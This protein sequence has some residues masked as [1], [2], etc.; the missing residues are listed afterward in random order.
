MSKLERKQ[1]V[2]RIIAF[3]VL[4]NII[5]DLVFP[6]C[7][8]ALTGGPS[9]PEFE[10]FEPAATN[11]MVD[12]FT[13]DLNYNIPLLNIPGPNGGYPV[14]L[15][16]HAGP[17][18]EQEASW[19]GLG[20]NI[21]PGVIN[22]N[23]RGLPDDFNGDVVTKEFNLKDRTGF[24]IS[25][26]WEGNKWCG[27]PFLPT[28]YSLGITYDNYKGF[29]VAGSFSY[30]GN[31]GSLAVNY[32]TQDG[33]GLQ[34]S[35]SVT[36]KGGTGIGL[37]VNLNS[38]EGM[39]SW[40]IDI[41]QKFKNVGS[42]G[43]KEDRNTSLNIGFA[44][45]TQV[46][47]IT[48]P[49]NTNLTMF[50]VRGYEAAFLDFNY[51]EVSGNVTSTKITTNNQP[52]AGYGYCYMQNNPK[53][54]TGAYLLDFNREND[55]PVT[56]DVEALPMPV[57]T[58]DLFSISGEGIG[59]AFRTQ[60]SDVGILSDPKVE[61][62][63]NGIYI[64]LEVGVG[65]LVHA[66]VSVPFILNEKDVSGRWADYYGSINGSTDI[67][68][69][70]GDESFTFKFLNEL[71]T[72]EGA[73]RASIN[74]IVGAES[75]DMNL[76]WDDVWHMFVPQI[77]NSFNG[78]AGAYSGNPQYRSMRR[79]RDK[80]IE[81]RKRSEL[82]SNN[83]GIGSHV[84]GSSTSN[85]PPDYLT[86]ENSLAKY[87]YSGHND[88][89]GEISV[90]KPDGFRYQY[91]IPV[92]QRSQKDVVFSVNATSN[93]TKNF[94]FSNQPYVNE[95][96]YNQEIVADNYDA[97][98]ASISNLESNTDNL[99]QSNSLPDYAGNYLLT[100][101][102]SP[103][104]VDLTGNGP[105]NDD[106][107]YYVKYNYQQTNAGYNWRTPYSG[108]FLTKGNFSDVLD[109][110]ESYMYGTKETWYLH[111]I[112]TKTH[113]A[114]FKTS[115]R[116]DG[117]DA[118]EIS[119]T[120]GSVLQ[121]PHKLK[122]LDQINLY[123]QADLA[124]PIQAINF[125]YD[126][127]LCKGVPNNS[128][129]GDGKLTLKKVWFS[130]LGNNKGQLSPYIFNYED[131]TNGAYQNPHYGT[132]NTDRW[133]NYKDPY[134][135]EGGVLPSFM[136][137]GTDDYPYVFQDL[138]YNHDGTVAGNSNGVADEYSLDNQQRNFN[139]SAW[140]L[141][142]IILPSGGQINIDYEQDEYAYV[143][144]QEATEMFQIVSTGHTPSNNNAPNQAFGGFTEE[145]HDDY[146]RIYFELKKDT[147]ASS[148]SLVDDISKY[149]PTTNSDGSPG[150]HH[151]YFKT[152]VELKS[153]LDF[154]YKARDYVSGYLDAVNTGTVTNG[155][156]KLGFIDVASIPVDNSAS[157]GACHPIRKAAWQHLKLNRH[158]LISPQTNSLSFGIALLQVV[159]SILTDA[160]QVILG[161]YHSCQ[162]NEYAYRLEL[163]AHGKP[164][165]IRLK[166]P[167]GHKKGGGHRVRRIAYTD[168]W[169]QMASDYGSSSPDT[170]GQEYSYLLPDG[171]SSGVASYEPL[172]GGEENPFKMP[173]RTYSPLNGWVPFKSLDLYLEKPYGEKY[174]PAPMVG[175]SRVI[176]KNIDRTTTPSGYTQPVISNQKS[177]AGV[178]VTDFYTAKDFPVRVAVGD[179][180]S[181]SFPLSIPVPLVGT[182]AWDN[183]GYSQGYE[184]VLNNMHG[185]LKSQATYAPM[186]FNK[187]AYGT[188]INSSMASPQAIVEY[189]YNTDS[190]GQLDNNVNVMDYD[191]SYRSSLIG[192][193]GEEFVDLREN[194]RIKDYSWATINFDMFLAA[195]VPVFCIVPWPTINYNESMYR[196]VVHNKIV[197]QTGVL[198]EVRTTKDG[199]TITMNNLMYDSNTGEPLLTSVTNNFN[200][201]VY[202]YNKQAYWAYN[203]MG[204]AYK[205]Y[206]YT[207]NTGGLTS[208]AFTI[209]NG[210]ANNFHLG[211]IVLLNNIYYWVTN[212]VPNLV[213]P[214]TQTNITLTDRNGTPCPSGGSLTIMKSGYTNQ[215]DLKMG[216]IVGLKN[217]ITG[218]VSNSL[219]TSYISNLNSL[220]P[221]CK[222]YNNCTQSQY[223]SSSSYTDCFGNPITYSFYFNNV[224]GVTTSFTTV[225]SYCSFWSTSTITMDYNSIN[226]FFNFGA[227]NYP[228][229]LNFSFGENVPLD[230][231]TNSTV[232]IFTN[233]QLKFIN[234]SWTPNQVI[235][236]LTPG[237]ILPPWIYPS[238]K[239]CIDLDSVLQT[240]AMHYTDQWNFNYNDIGSTN[241]I[242]VDNGANRLSLDNTLAAKNP[243]RFGM[244]GIWRPLNNWAYI[245]QRRQGDPSYIDAN[246]TPPLYSGAKHTKISVDGTFKLDEHDWTNNDRLYSPMNPNFNTSTSITYNPQWTFVSE[247]TNY[248]PYGY[249]TEKV[250]AL[251]IYSTTLY[252]YNNILKSAEASNSSYYETA[253]EGFEDHKGIYSGAHG[254]VAFTSGSVA[255][256]TPLSSLSSSQ[257]HTGYYSLPFSS[258]VSLNIPNQQ[259]NA[260]TPN[261]TLS[262][263]TPLLGQNKYLLSFWIKRNSS[264]G[265]ITVT[266]T[267]GTNNSTELGPI[268]D[269]WQKVDYTFTSP[270]S[271]VTPFTIQISAGNSTVSYIDDIRIQPFTSAM[272]TYVYDPNKLWL[273]SELDNRNFATFYNYDEEGQVV[274][275]KKET[276]KGI[277]T[278]KTSR[279][280][281]RRNPN[282]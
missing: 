31:Y 56:K 161:F 216:H 265:N 275:V 89:F 212:M 218:E 236:T 277:V 276:E 65:E 25:F 215:Q 13:G 253:F 8:F 150:T 225:N 243:F 69:H 23:M 106:M 199:S 36:S 33:M 257:Y 268:I 98:S 61:N 201:P 34:L 202:T 50:D 133:G 221:Y 78:G 9:Q 209:N 136:P 191:G 19:V 39:T 43:H 247:I 280:N 135:K 92:Y 111:S 79:K 51:M 245:D 16:Y 168:N 239:M 152:L 94:F 74:S 173:S 252:G 148:N 160:E 219:P 90:V 11:Q 222:G 68:F 121:G 234:N 82:A 254:H 255:V 105:S 75:L 262:N 235:A 227:Q 2:N 230:F 270:N 145:L 187:T 26:G 21:N 250:D 147:L 44:T 108:V 6:T 263:F 178:S 159:M 278:V 151:I 134:F 142:Q 128:N 139:A 62:T 28:P 88:H 49:M 116:N 273:L 71:N 170:Y 176:V 180:H 101:V 76:A 164:S 217:P 189:I 267:I 248:N 45:S 153:S 233:N 155:S 64:G 177:L 194:S 185:Q 260:Y 238:D 237:T 138:D 14:N 12:L 169:N 58:N 4:I 165:F 112:E 157:S 274:Q 258:S 192:Q 46:P 91:G 66:G 174:Y 146:T 29:G 242:Q 119:G 232:S 70:G 186:Y 282:P 42:K 41:S 127:T 20:W 87:S 5:G 188:N 99:Y 231:F 193:E 171:R 214:T 84:T 205:N 182:I 132:N 54:L 73:E 126:Y 22:R 190:K 198:K 60:R 141:R 200:E 229:E 113:I 59:G 114:I 80:L 115:D 172:Q 40:G 210:V 38:R 93:S 203:S 120:T 96:S 125:S 226:L 206:R 57:M 130:Y 123:S 279:N 3:F 271:S 83:I 63:T 183:R 181:N 37:S 158:D 144:D 228:N 47:T 95:A 204:P 140:C 109:D 103:D 264:S 246:N 102:Y 24:E 163:N 224:F 77:K 197:Q 110:K 117:I 48:W 240:S 32:D 166:N 18:M 223:G 195:L 27:I 118:T 81:Y 30:S 249:V 10:S 281:I 35:P 241:P 220:L 272:K 17:T 167:T 15:A 104:Y 137:C 244:A 143:Q 100:A 124:N 7:A 179:M 259:A 131:A 72:D 67:D 256:G 208:G 52:F 154:K 129:N 122:K 266:N 1:R 251:G 207:W 156:S 196:S 175:Y 211:D 86:Y 149:F 55:Y 269:G 213:N 162:A 184:I 53:A 97:G 107:G 85:T 261:N